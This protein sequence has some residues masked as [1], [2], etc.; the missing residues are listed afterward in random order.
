[1]TLSQDLD[2]RGTGASPGTVDAA[3]HN[4]SANNIYIGRFNTSGQI[5][6]RG[7]I[8]AAAGLFV[9]RSNFNF[10][11]S[12]SAS[13]L[14]ASNGAIVNLN[15]ATALNNIQIQSGGQ[16]TTAAAGNVSQG[17]LIQDASSQLTLG[18]NMTLSQDLDI[19]GTGASPGT[20]DAAGHDITANNMFIGRFGTAGQLLNDGAVTVNSDL[21][22]DSSTVTLHGGND[23]VKGNLQLDLASSLTIQ[24]AIGGLTGLTLGGSSLSILDT[25]VLHLDF[26]SSVVPGLDWVFR[27]ANPGSGDRVAA[28]D[29]LISSGLITVS[30]NPLAYNV[31]N[32]GDGYTYV[33][34]SAAPEPSTVALFGMGIGLVAISV[35]RRSKRLPRGESS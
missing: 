34:Y 26:D 23:Q 32:G 35:R 28:I 21:S 17:V 1:M 18:A 25:S 6:N 24:Q 22:I 15:A 8:T 4:I 33:G 13:T 19:R 16:V 2:I 27:W 9:D 10:N 29:G 31:F 11:A 5:L 20:V 12:D 30:G 14:G 3:G 7:T